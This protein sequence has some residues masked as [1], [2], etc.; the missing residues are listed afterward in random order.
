M[1]YSH[2]GV[3][4][5]TGAAA[6]R[7]RAR[8]VRAPGARTV[9]GRDAGAERRWRPGLAARR[10]ASGPACVRR[11][12]DIVRNDALERSVCRRLPSCATFSRVYTGPASDRLSTA[13]P[14]PNRPAAP[15]RLRIGFAIR[16]PV[17]TATTAMPSAERRKVSTN[18]APQAGPPPRRRAR[19]ARRRATSGRS[20]TTRPGGARGRAG[21]SARGAAPPGCGRAAPGG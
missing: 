10:P 4:C 18:V 13:S 16:L 11:A 12:E 3:A 19:A 6:A 14:R 9:A 7:V 17:R 20:G 15:A 1:N 21:G 2:N 5:A 8:K